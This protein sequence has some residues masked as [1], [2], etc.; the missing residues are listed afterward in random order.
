MNESH[1][2]LA[3]ISGQFTKES[4][5]KLKWPIAWNGTPDT[6][7]EGA[8]HAL[9]DEI[10]ELIDQTPDAVGVLVLRGEIDSVEVVSEDS[11]EN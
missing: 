3:K 5:L 4:A 11:E 8:L 9:A 2:N 1:P 10:V 7:Y 6:E